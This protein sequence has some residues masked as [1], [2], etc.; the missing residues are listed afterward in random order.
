LPAYF[1]PPDTQQIIANHLDTQCT[2]IDSIV[3]K[4]IEEIG[5][6][7]EYRTRLI[8]DIV[9]GRKDVRGV[10]I[11]KFEIVSA[12]NVEAEEEQ[13]DENNQ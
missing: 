5:L 12:E 9:T 13:D 7:A 2:K 11:P 3:T 8:S 1:S 4:L 6:F 10:V